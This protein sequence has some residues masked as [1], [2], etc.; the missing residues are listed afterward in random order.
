[1]RRERSTIPKIWQRNFRTRLLQEMSLF[2][3]IKIFI[4]FDE[5]INSEKLQPND[6]QSP[7]GFLPVQTTTT[8]WWRFLR[9][10]FS[11][12][13]SNKNLT[14]FDPKWDLK[15]GTPPL[16]SVCGVRDSR[17]FFELGSW[18]RGSNNFVS[19]GQTLDLPFRGWEPEPNSRSWDFRNA[20]PWAFPQY[21]STDQLN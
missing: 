3:P 20:V 9:I 2:S 21:C 10:F 7:T 6:F 1:M 14:C 8:N 12:S 11:F 4:I 18:K 17:C 5:N 19:S 15:I 16:K 13:G